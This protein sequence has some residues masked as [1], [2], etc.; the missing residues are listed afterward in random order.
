MYLF[1]TALVARLN[2]FGGTRGGAGALGRDVR[3]GAN[4]GGVTGKWVSLILCPH[5]RKDK[6]EGKNAQDCKTKRN[7][8]HNS[9]SLSLVELLPR[10]ALRCESVANTSVS[11]RDRAGVSLKGSVATV[12]WSRTL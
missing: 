1:G 4:S 12:T 5:R 6:R 2:L 3:D 10:L 11:K 9:S 8:S 7:F